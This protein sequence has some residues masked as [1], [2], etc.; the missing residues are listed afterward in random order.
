[1]DPDGLEEGERLLE[2]LLK[3]E[4]GEEVGVVEM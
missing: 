2:A 3:L 1:M 4:N